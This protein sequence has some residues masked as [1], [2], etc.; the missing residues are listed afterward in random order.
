MINIQKGPLG[1]MLLDKG[2]V[3]GTERGCTD[4]SRVEVL[5]SRISETFRFRRC[6]LSAGN[7]TEMIFMRRGVHPSKG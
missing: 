4:I 1:M 3:E 5:E 7:R 2:K 6:H